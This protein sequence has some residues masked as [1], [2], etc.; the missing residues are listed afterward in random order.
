M[1]ATN[2]R[3]LISESHG[4]SN[5]C[6]PCR[7]KPDQHV[8]YASHSSSRMFDVRFLRHSP[9]V[10][11]FHWLPRSRNMP[12]HPEE[13]LATK[14]RLSRS[15][16][17]VTSFILSCDNPGVGERRFG[18]M[19]T[20][21]HQ[22]S[23][24]ILP[25]CDRYVQYLLTGSTERSLIDTC[26]GYNLGGVGLPRTHSLTFPISCLRFSLRAPSGLQ[27]NQVSAIKPKF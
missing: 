16:S 26:G 24:L 4:D 20:Q 1:I 11:T 13:V 2:K 18:P 9:Y 23:G 22:L 7:V 27:F 17:W 3:L 12:L 5:R 15:S 6:T 25:A 10:T 19:V 8:T 21:L 14:D